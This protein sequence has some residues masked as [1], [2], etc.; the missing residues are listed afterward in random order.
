LSR[1]PLLS[2]ERRER[3]V[4]AR[5]YNESMRPLMPMVLVLAAVLGEPAAALAQ[6]DLR[7]S[8]GRVWLTARDATVAQILGEWARIG[9][10]QIVNGD[11]V[12]G[13]PLTLQLDDVSEQEALDLLLRSAVGFVAARRALPIATIS[14]FDRILILPR[15]SPLPAPAPPASPPPAAPPVFPEAEPPPVFAPVPDVQP[16]IGPDGL[17]VPDDQEGAPVGPPPPTP[18]T[19]APDVPAGVPTP[20]MIVPVP[21]PQPLASPPDR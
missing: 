18:S 17:P 14:R 20:G 7:I 2:A 5:G 11:R 4:T 8:D 1:Q 21:E 6:V 19:P 3:T 10:T 15:G 12:P 16:V 9:Q 13:G